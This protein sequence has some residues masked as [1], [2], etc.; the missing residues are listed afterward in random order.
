MTRRLQLGFRVI[1]IKDYPIMENL[2]SIPF[3]IFWVEEVNTATHS[4]EK[5]IGRIHL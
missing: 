4:E 2:P 1:P 3:P 5:V